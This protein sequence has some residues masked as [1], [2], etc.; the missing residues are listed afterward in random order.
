MDPVDRG[1]ILIM[2]VI[3]DVWIDASGLELSGPEEEALTM[4]ATVGAVESKRLY[5]CR[6]RGNSERLKVVL[7][8]LKAT[9]A[10]GIRQSLANAA[11]SKC[12]EWFDGA[13]QVAATL[14]FGAGRKHLRLSGEG[15]RLKEEF[16]KSAPSYLCEHVRKQFTFLMAHPFPPAHALCIESCRLV[17]PAEATPTKTEVLASVTAISSVDSTEYRTGAWF[18]DQ[19][20]ARIRSH[21]DRHPDSIRAMGSGRARVFHLGDVRPLWTDEV[22]K[23]EE[24]HR[25]LPAPRR[26][27]TRKE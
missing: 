9:S 16:L 26:S 4:L 7:V 15:A 12:P 10:E 17:K 21:L 23:V 22:A 25:S 18:G 13:H 8:T 2:G 19:L 6:V 3:P 14:H 24:Y 20:A 5:T 27:R 1:I 11:W